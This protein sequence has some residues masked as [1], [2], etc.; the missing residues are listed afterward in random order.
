MEE[1]G[2]VMGVVLGGG[3]VGGG[4]ALT[5]TI[6]VLFPES[7]RVTAV[8]GGHDGPAIIT[9]LQFFF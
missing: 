3:W 9:R 5:C 1:R 2:L 7:A 4:G 8:D 6:L